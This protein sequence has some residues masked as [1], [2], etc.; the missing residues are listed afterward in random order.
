MPIDYLR[1]SV[2]RAREYSTVIFFHA[3]SLVRILYATFIIVKTFVF[4][5]IKFSTFCN[6]VS[7]FC[8]I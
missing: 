6:I 4:N 7:P 1:G 8:L 2:G 5:F 3:V